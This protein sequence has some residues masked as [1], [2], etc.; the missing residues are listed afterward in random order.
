[1]DGD[2]DPSGN[3]TTKA[4]HALDCNKS[5]LRSESDTQQL[6]GIGLKDIMAIAMPDA[7]LVAHRERAQDV[8]RAVSLLKLEG[9][10]QAEA[11]PKDYR[12]WGWF[13]SLAMGQG[14]QVKRIHVKPGGALSLQSH[15]C[16]S[17]HGTASKTLTPCQWY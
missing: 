14:F 15:E 5:L 9:V 11:F 6:V 13:E 4:A 8:K 3:V 1:M 12:P 16:R 17:V 2:K 7:V 10:G